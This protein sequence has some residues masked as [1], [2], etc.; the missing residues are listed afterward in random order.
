MQTAFRAGLIILLQQRN[1]IRIENP[2]MQF[3]ALSFIAY[4]PSNLGSRS[5]QKFSEP[6]VLRTNDA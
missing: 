1:D 2:V 5:R 6:R 3:L 4:A